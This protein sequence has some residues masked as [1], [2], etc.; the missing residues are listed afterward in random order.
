MLPLYDK[1]A[2]SCIPPVTTPFRVWLSGSR[3]TVLPGGASR[4]NLSC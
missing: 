4:G 1:S 3:V 2:H